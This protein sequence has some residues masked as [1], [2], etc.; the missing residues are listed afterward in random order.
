MKKV[1]YRPPIDKLDLSSE[2]ELDKWVP[3]H[4]HYRLYEDDI[5]SFLLEGKLT[6]TEFKVL[7]YVGRQV[8]YL[9]RVCINTSD[10]WDGINIRRDMVEACLKSLE[11][12]GLIEVEHRDTNGRGSRVIAVNPFLYWLGDY[13]LRESYMKRWVFRQIKQGLPEDYLYRPREDNGKD[14]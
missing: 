2:E 10:I 11:E 9:N 8:K 4:H 3:N 7:V 12:K 1:E 5:A 13:R 14:L 6:V